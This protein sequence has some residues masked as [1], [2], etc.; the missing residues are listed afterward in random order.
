MRPRG[1]R[2][3]WRAQLSE[4]TL[5]TEV[6]CLPA[7]S[8]GAE[9]VLFLPQRDNHEYYVTDGEDRFFILS[10]GESFV[11]RMQ[12]IVD[13]QDGLREIPRVQRRS[14]GKPLEFYFSKGREGMVQAYLT[15]DY[16]MQE[17]AN[18]YGVHYSTVSRAVK[19]DCEN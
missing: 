2:P 17:I 14:K 18:Y 8:P 7:A 9:P 19:K 13:V 12:K 6:R 11:T 4:S 16:T 15:G 10:T 3:G 5:A 1:K